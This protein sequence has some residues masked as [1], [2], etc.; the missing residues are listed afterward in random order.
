ML[1]LGRRLNSDIPDSLND[2]FSFWRKYY[3][4]GIRS[5]ISPRVR[6]YN[7]YIDPILGK[8]YFGMLKVEP[9]YLLNDSST[10][11]ISLWSGADFAPGHLLLN[12]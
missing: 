8:P 6:L 2:A 12:H 9:F 7:P 1:C 10:I 11:I 4:K 5:N 3:N